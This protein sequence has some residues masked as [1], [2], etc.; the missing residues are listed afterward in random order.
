M[1]TCI[2]ECASTCLI[3]RY[4][5]TVLAICGILLWA[6][7]TRPLCRN[8]STAIPYADHSEQSSVSESIVPGDHIQLLYHFWLCR[9]MIAGNTPT[10]SNVYEFNTGDDSVR[11]KF[12]PFYIP[13]SLVYCI[14]SPLFGNAAGWNAAGLFS[15]FLGLFGIYVLVRRYGASPCL[16]ILISLVATAHPYRW[17]TLFGGS[18]TGFASGL[19]PWVLCGLDGIVRDKSWKYGLLAGFSLFFA[20]CSDLHVFYFSTLLSPCWCIFAFL[21]SGA[22]F[23]LSKIEIRKLVVAFIPFVVLAFAAAVA[24]VS[25]SEKLAGSTMASGRTIKELC[26][27]TPEVNGL[28]A[29]KHLGISN[30]IFCGNLAI[31]FL[32]F[33]LI[34]FVCLGKKHKPDEETTGNRRQASNGTPFPGHGAAQAAADGGCNCKQLMPARP[35]VL[36]LLLAAAVCMVIFLSLGANGP[37]WGFP[38]RAARRLIP[39]YTMIRQPMKVLSVVAPLL[40]VLYALLLAPLFRTVSGRKDRWLRVAVICM[41]VAAVAEIGLWFSPALC[42]LPAKLDAYVSAADDASGKHID[43]PGAL[44]V[45]MWPGDSHWSSIYEYGVISSRL[46][47]VNGYSPAVP[48]E[49]FEGVFSKLETVNHGFLSEEQ[50]DLM[51]SHGIRYVLFHEQP[52]PSKVSPFPSSVALRRLR[53]NQRLELICA[54]DGIWTFAVDTNAKSNNDNKPLAPVMYSDFPASYHWSA[55][56]LSDVRRIPGI[57]K[58]Y[59]TR[60]RAPI[61]ETPEMRYLIL[62]SGGGKIVSESGVE[63]PIPK[64]KEWISVPFAYPYG[65]N[66]GTVEGQPCLEHVLIAAGKYEPEKTE[67]VWSGGML[68]HTGFSDPETGSV[69][70][71]ASHIA[72]CLLYGPDIPFPK[73]K[74]VAELDCEFEGEG[75]FGALLCEKILKPI[76]VSGIVSVEFQYDGL[77]PLRVEVHSHGGRVFKI[78]TLTLR[79]CE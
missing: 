56:K 18:P 61:P 37:L 30:H 6:V 2:K 20:Y 79:L 40:A 23:S 55:E 43:K 39:K 78:K 25:T 33:A 69:T 77:H 8:F 16:S 65:E 75:E 60:L 10:F 74:Y 11:F 29:W 15:V 50:I 73:G 66:F 36:I 9:D 67:F 52:Y 54:S 5:K 27:F 34:V 68:F 3:S 42:R 19:V 32:V 51:I 76:S 59:R 24:V 70:F 57:A 49:Y 14:V 46:R 31:L 21:A 72:G 7:F 58:K 22:K 12:D 47:L 35:A 63:I 41:A 1:P 71:P 62:A 45:P 4:P 44:A 17:I 26:L 28:I 38:I 64:E 48:A 53:S 13:F